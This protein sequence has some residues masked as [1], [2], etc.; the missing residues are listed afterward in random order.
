MKEGKSLNAVLQDKLDR[1]GCTKL[2]YKFNEPLIFGAFTLEYALN[3]ECK[4]RQF[5]SSRIFHELFS[6]ARSFRVRVC[7]SVCEKCGL[8]TFRARIRGTTTRGMVIWVAYNVSISPEGNNVKY[9][10]LPVSPFTTLYCAISTFNHRKH[11]NCTS[12]IRLP[13]Y[14]EYV[15]GN[16]ISKLSKLPRPSRHKR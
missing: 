14:I 11:Q 13:V 15:I 8:Y 2:G 5:L 1:H 10:R 6:R 7:L 9:F 12:R 4:S 3:L 16:G